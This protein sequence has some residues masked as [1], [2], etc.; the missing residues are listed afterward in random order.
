MFYTSFAKILFLSETQQ[1]F[2]IFY[3]QAYHQYLFSDYYFQREF[4]RIEHKF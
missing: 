3:E 1:P 4:S 2:N